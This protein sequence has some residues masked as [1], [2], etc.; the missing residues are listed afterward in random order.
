MTKMVLGY[1]CGE[2]VTVSAQD[3]AIVNHRVTTHFAFIGLTEV[4]S[5]F[6]LLSILHLSA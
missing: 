5:V 4:Y 6:N 2:N 1:R 3:L